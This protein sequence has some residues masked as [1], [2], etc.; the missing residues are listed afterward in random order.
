MNL[1]EIVSYNINEMKGLIELDLS[2]SKLSKL[3]D[4][5]NLTSLVSLK[6]SHNIHLEGEIDLL[7]EK[8]RYRLHKK[9][10]YWHPSRSHS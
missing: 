4:I 1:I 8:I 6:L 9:D 3:S 2:Y 7:I 5:R 10:S